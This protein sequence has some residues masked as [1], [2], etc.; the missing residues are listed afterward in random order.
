MCCYR[1]VTNYFKR[2]DH[3]VPLPDE[4]IECG[5]PR[6]VHSK[7]HD[8]ACVEPECR[9]TCIQYRTHP[10]RYNPQIDK[11][12]PYCQEKLMRMQRGY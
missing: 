9:R 12:C 10:Q 8:P 2:C 11:L 6:C 3:S 1:F 4:Q 7:Y 5:N